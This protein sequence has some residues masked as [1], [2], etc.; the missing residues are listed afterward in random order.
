MIDIVKALN[1]SIVKFSFKKADGSERIALGTRNIDY[2]P[3][4][5][6]PKGGVQDGLVTED[7]EGVKTIRY[8]DFDAKGWRSFKSDKFVGI[9]P[10]GKL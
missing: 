4:D 2:V 10:N 6:L 1:G 5:K 7:H 3:D 8:Y 9:V